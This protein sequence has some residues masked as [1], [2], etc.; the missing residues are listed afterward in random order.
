MCWL[1]VNQGSG[2]LKNGVSF[3]VFLVY[4]QNRNLKM[5]YLRV[6]L[7]NVEDKSV[8]GPFA[9][10]FDAS[11]NFSAEV[12]WSVI[13]LGRCQDITALETQFY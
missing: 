3:C 5:F 7:E 11:C 4:F 12:G 13:L 8:R 10:E 2:A 9:L 1:S 6:P